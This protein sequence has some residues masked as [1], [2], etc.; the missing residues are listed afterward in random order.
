MGCCSDDKFGNSHE[1]PNVE[2]SIQ[3]FALA[4]HPVSEKEFAEFLGQDSENPT[5]PLVNVSWHEASDYCH[6]LGDE[7]GETYRLPTE[8]EW[9]YAC[10]AGTTTPFPS[11]FMSSPEQANCYYDEMGNRI[12]VGKRLPRSWGQPNPFGLH[13]MLGNVCEWVE[14]DWVPDFENLDPEGAAQ[15]STTEMKVIRGGGWDSMPRLARSSFRD[16]LSPS[17]RRDNLGFRVAKDL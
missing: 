6:W 1:L 12:G 2:V 8:S 11:G 14:D 13:D 17:S 16:F 10:R 5:L 7:S 15:R 3:S 4:K 9:E